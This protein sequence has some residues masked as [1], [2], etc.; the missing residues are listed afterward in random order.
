[1]SVTDPV[2]PSFPNLLHSLNATGCGGRLAILGRP[3]LFS[4]VRVVHALAKW[5]DSTGRGARE[6]GS[7]GNVS[8]LGWGREVGSLLGV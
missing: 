8:A 1:M 5:S 4:S 7:K 6:Q 3:T 2:L